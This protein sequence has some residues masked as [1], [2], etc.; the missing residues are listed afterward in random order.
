M[1]RI[2]QTSR[3]PNNPK[4]IELVKSTYRPT[5]AEIK[6]EF[7]IDLH[8]LVPS[9][10]FMFSHKVPK[11]ISYGYQ[12]SDTASIGCDSAMKSSEQLTDGEG[13]RDLIVVPDRHLLA[14]RR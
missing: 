14:P 8:F 4:S 10:I 2:G 6:E 1:H 9:P 3:K 5:K 7:N 13:S 11:L 12:S